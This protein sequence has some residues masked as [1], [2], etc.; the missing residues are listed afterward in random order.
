MRVF[1]RVN[2]FKGVDSQTLLDGDR[3]PVAMVMKTV[4]FKA[5][6][7]LTIKSASICKT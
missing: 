2:Q 6:L 3:S 7:V 1:L 4:N 5:K